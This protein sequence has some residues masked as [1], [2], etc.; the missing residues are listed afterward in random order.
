[1][2]AWG[3]VGTVKDDPVNRLKKP[4][5]FAGLGAEEPDASDRIL[6]ALELGAEAAGVA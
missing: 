1:M 4:E 5:D 3:V 6:G 2:G